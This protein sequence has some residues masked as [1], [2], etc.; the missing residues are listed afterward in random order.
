MET[1]IESPLPP[2]RSFG[3]ARA[4][5]VEV[6]Q[7]MGFSKAHGRREAPPVAGEAGLTSPGYQE[8]GRSCRPRKAHR[9]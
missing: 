1:G 2:K 8:A 9:R 4:K 7:Q 5:R 6:Y 3:C